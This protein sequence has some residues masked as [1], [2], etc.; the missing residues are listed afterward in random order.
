MISSQGSMGRVFTLRLEDGDRIPECIER[1]AAEQGIEAAFCSLVGGIDN[2][3]LVVGP[4]DGTAET[5]TPMFHTVHGA[6]E[7][8]AVGAIFSN[9]EGKPILHMHAAL[10]REEAT[11]TGCV[12]PGL[13]VWTV[14]EVVLMEILGTDMV[15]KHDPKIGLELLGKA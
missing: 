15:R 3:N 13:D 8:V 11:T 10:G 9:I 6:H 5:L 2:G 1:F 4:E 12:R 7:A 14:A